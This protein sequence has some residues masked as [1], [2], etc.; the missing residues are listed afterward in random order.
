MALLLSP[1]FPQCR[2]PWKIASGRPAALYKKKNTERVLVSKDANNATAA[3]SSSILSTV[4]LHFT[5]SG[6]D[7]L[8][9]FFK[10]NK[11]GKKTIINATDLFHSVV[12]HSLR[13]DNGSFLWTGCRS[14]HSYKDLACTGSLASLSLMKTIVKQQINTM[15][16]L[17]CVSLQFV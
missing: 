3:A 13:T 2:R 15:Q 10:E 8:F 12:L 5:Q 17:F 4:R 16:S 6:S 14:H 1:L 9:F 7:F 11:A